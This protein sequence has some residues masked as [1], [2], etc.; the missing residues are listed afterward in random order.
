MNEGAYLSYMMFWCVAAHIFLLLLIVNYTQHLEED[1]RRTDWEND[2]EFR[3]REDIEEG[4][5]IRRDPAARR[6]I[7]ED[8]RHAQE[9]LGMTRRH[10]C[11]EESMVKWEDSGF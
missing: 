3:R 4:R 2:D 9:V 6:S 11:Q 8:I 5:R 7:R 1:S 10:I